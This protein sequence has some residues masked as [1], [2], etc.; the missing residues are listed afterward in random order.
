MTE[1]LHAL[2]NQI[3]LLG[4]WGVALFVLLYITFAVTLVP[5]FP[6]TVAA[7]AIYGVARGSALVFLSATIGAV[8]AYGVAVRL[9]DS[10][11][12]RRLDREPRVVVVRDAIRE[13]GVWV[14][15][16]LRL[17]PIVPFTLLNYSL[18]LARVRLRDFMTALPGMLPAIVMYTYYGR[19]VGDV[20]ALAAGRAAPRGAAYYSLLVVGVVATAVASTVVTRAAGRAMRGK[21]TGRP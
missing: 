17:S 9:A 2:I 3:A 6:L 15:F 12:L 5:P 4:G 18:G 19:V 20:A 8:L 10:R 14:Q 16:L 7:G 21:A 1:W 11:L 13:E